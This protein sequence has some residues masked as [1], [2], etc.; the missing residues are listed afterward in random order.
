[1]DNL[2]QFIGFCIK[3]K[4]F[5]YTNVE[6]ARK[7]ILGLT[8]AKNITLT[9]DCE[10]QWTEVPKIVAL[11]WDFMEQEAENLNNFDEDNVYSLKIN[12]V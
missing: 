4:S 9:L 8:F 2:T 11:L 5:W 10:F 6:F 7:R 1:M 12:M 3:D